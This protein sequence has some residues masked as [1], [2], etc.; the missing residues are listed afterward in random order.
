MP[1]VFKRHRRLLGLCL[2]SLALTW[3]S[4]AEPT[5]S[6]DDALCLRLIQVPDS[7]EAV[8]WL[9]TPSAT[10]KQ[11]GGL[12][13]VDALALVSRL[14][15][16]GAV[17]STAVGIRE[18]DSSGIVVELPA[19]PSKRLAVFRLC[20]KLARVGGLAGQRDLGQRYLHVPWTH[21]SGP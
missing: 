21:Q 7:F 10:P 6:S 11:P 2:A 5:D 9:K 8:E 13:T 14:D 18:S 16:A 20:D 12:S 15:Q 1:G 4:C 17:R 19:D 3:P